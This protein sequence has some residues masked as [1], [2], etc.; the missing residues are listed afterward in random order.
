ML[1]VLLTAVP[2]V[3]DL[4]WSGPEAVFRYFAADAFYYHTV[5]RNLATLGVATFDQVNPT[6]GFHPLWQ[7]TT[8]LAYGLRDAFG[9]TEMA[10]LQ[11]TLI[12]GV[13][14]VTGSVLLFGICL[15][16]SGRLSPAFVGLP[17]GLYAVIVMPAWLLA[18]GYVN[19][20][21]G[22]LP[23]YGTLWSQV[24][25]ME[26]AFALFSF[27]CLAYVLCR[28]DWDSIGWGA[29]VGFWAAATTLSRLD[30]V[31]LVWPLAALPFVR[32]LSRRDAQSIRVAAACAAA[33]V[34]PVVIYLAVNYS[35]MGV[36]MPVSGSAKSTFPRP[37]TG[38]VRWLFIEM[39]SGD[40]R[41][42]GWL[43]GTLRQAQIVVPAIAALAYL[44]VAAKAG[45]VQRLRT[46]AD[47]RGMDLVLPAAAVGVLA[48]AAYNFLFVPPFAMGPWY[49]PVST[50]FVSLVALHGLRDVQ[51]P[52]AGV[53]ALGIAA[54]VVFLTLQRRDGYHEEFA[55][56][57][58][59]DAADVRRHYTNLSPR[60]IEQDDG[61]V[62]FATGI[63]SMSGF[64]FADDPE[65]AR[66][67]RAGR[68]VELAL[69]RGHSTW[70]TLVYGPPATG[71]LAALERTVRSALGVAESHSLHVEYR[72][73][74]SRFVAVR[75]Q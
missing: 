38:N 37:H 35:Y 67:R 7:G 2:V 27:A 36:F 53:A 39:L 49:F 16:S 65:A 3:V 11:T 64:G 47:R 58:L 57:Y 75:I 18:S 71:D 1:A 41:R 59:H 40:P 62:A 60:F 24:N 63:P 70:V 54:I 13:V 15:A 8:A 48:L 32:M 23:L 22:P 45:L 17:V 50:I 42:P 69:V 55:R 30:H 68:L 29:R 31:L 34:V 5:A 46:L 72:S 10:Y 25:G 9:L 43:D 33:T 61:I 56:F 26:S 21:E 74:R 14:C 12:L 73:S 4:A 20:H 28:P 52:P 51:I 19:S 44:A 6:N 66:A